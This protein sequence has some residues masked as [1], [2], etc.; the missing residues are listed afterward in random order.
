MYRVKIP[1]DSLLPKRAIFIPTVSALTTSNEILMEA[2]RHGY[3]VKL[4][5][6]IRD[7][8]YGVLVERRK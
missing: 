1:W 6:C 5:T 8:L 4:T 3:K 2:A 7:G